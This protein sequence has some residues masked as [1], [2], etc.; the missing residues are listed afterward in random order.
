LGSDRSERKV[1]ARRTLTIV[2]FF[3]PHWIGL[4]ATAKRIAEALA[5]EVTQSPR[6]AARLIREHDITQIHTPLPVR[7]MGM[8]LLVSRQSPEAATP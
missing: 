2:T 7:A 5:P 1:V 6:E 8:G 3:H 4:T